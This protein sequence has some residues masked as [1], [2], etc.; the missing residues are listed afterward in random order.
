MYN[1]N[2]NNTLHFKS[3]SYSNRK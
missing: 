3:H 1:N 2:N